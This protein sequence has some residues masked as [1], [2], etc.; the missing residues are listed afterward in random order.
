MGMGMCLKNVRRQ[1]MLNL[2]ASQG[3]PGSGNL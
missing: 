3:A 1:T 2:S